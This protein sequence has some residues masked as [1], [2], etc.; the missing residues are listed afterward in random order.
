MD[1]HTDNILDH[2]DHVL[3][4]VE[5]SVDLRKVYVHPE[6]DIDIGKSISY[7]CKLSA[8]NCETCG[9]LLD[10]DSNDWEFHG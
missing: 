5:E 10:I 3:T 6:G 7:D 8:I 2:I 1:E 9:R 4:Y